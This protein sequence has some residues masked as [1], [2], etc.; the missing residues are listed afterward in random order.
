MKLSYKGKILDV[1]SENGLLK[2]DG[3]TTPVE[4]EKC[5]ENILK[6]KLDGFERTVY[7]ANDNKY[8][9]VF[10][11]G[12]QY[13]FQQIDESIEI[14]ET[15]TETV[16]NEEQIKPPMPGSVVKLLVQQGQSVEEGA[17]IIVVEAMKMEITLYSSISGVVTEINVEPGQQVDS[18]KTLVVIKRNENA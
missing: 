1:E 17:P 9:Y 11:D 2:V 3:T 4:I 8:A 14:D 7:I 12:E 13:T 18:D 5:S 16:K 15:R 6:I 10:I